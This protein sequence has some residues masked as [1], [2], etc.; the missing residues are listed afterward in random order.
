MNELQEL[1]NVVYSLIGQFIKANFKFFDIGIVSEVDEVNHCAKVIISPS[2]DTE[3]TWCSVIEAMASQ[4]GTGTSFLPVVG[5]HVL[6]HYYNGSRNSPVIFGG[7]FSEAM[8]PPSGGKAGEPSFFHKSGSF[9]KLTNDGKV[10][11]NGHTEID[12][13]TPKL[14][15]TTTSEVEITSP[16]INLAKDGGTPDRL[17]KLSD[18]KSYINDHI[19]SNGNAGANTGVPTVL[20]TDAVGTTVVKGE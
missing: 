8:K 6:I 17:V 2:E 11:V 12:I 9:V 7:I 10:V 5:D 4:D 16:A 19:H 14:V 1:F 3:T 13:T 18:L 15:I 20:L